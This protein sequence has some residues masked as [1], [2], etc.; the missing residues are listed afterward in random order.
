MDVMPEYKSLR[1]GQKSF[2]GALTKELRPTAD[3]S[4]LLRRLKNE[5]TQKK[6]FEEQTQKKAVEV[7]A[8]TLSESSSKYVTFS[9]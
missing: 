2:F 1:A 4:H 7:V 8:T 3:E 9:K 5:R 6:T